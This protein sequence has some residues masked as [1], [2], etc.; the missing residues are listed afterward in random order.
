[1]SGEAAK[2]DLVFYNLGEVLDEVRLLRSGYRTVGQW[3]LAQICRHLAD[4]IHAS[5]D[6]FDL[7]RHRIKRWVFARP[8][9]AYTY[10]YGIPPG[11]TVDPNLTPP[12][13]VK[14]DP[15]IAEMEQAIR[16]YL[17]HTGRLYPH[18]LFGRLSRGGWDRL[19]CFHCAHHLRYAVPEGGLVG[20]RAAT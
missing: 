6:G 15:S 2:R 7:R 8:L 9:L 5:M 4:T 11:Y 20:E 12:R 18:P 16:R 3:T 17:D 14:L 1:M 19:H 13:D 10:R